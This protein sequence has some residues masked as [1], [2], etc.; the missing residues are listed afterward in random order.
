MNL[1]K[2]YFKDRK[3]YQGALAILAGTVLLVSTIIGFTQDTKS[4]AGLIILILASIAMI[5]GAV[6]NNLYN[7]INQIK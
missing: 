2:K 1:I 4:V 7:H 5:G 3:S 6:V